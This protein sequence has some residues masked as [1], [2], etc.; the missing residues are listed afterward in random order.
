MTTTVIYKARKKFKY[1]GKWLKAG[2]VWEPVGGKWDGHL[3]KNYVTVEEVE[4][5]DDVITP[6]KKPVTRRR[7]SGTVGK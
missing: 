2:D 5:I 7:R 3:K 1:D 6:V 4:V